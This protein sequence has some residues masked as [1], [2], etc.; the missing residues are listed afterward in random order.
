MIE[1]LERRCLLH[2]GTAEIVSGIL[3]I[4][5]T[6]HADRIVL[7]YGRGRAGQGGDGLTLRVRIDRERLTFNLA[8]FSGILINTYEGNDRVVARVQLPTDG[9]TGVTIHGGE[10]NDRLY[11]SKHADQILG[12]AGNDRIRGYGGND[13]IFGGDG[14]DLL[15]G[16][17]GDDQLDGDT[18]RDR[19]KGGGDNDLIDGDEGND[20]LWGGSGNDTLDGDEGN[21]RIWGNGG[22]DSL[23]A[24]LGSDRLYGNRGDDQLFADGAEADDGTTD[25]LNGGSGNDKAKSD[26][27]DILVGIEESLV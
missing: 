7:D 22:D 8:D 18:G 1:Q 9:F 6:D 17:K 2:S 26:A 23:V 19:I 16:D 21:D 15:V 13:S 12:D 4:N 25:F 27:E 11:G 20:R 14:N 24:G 10:G 5:G 3:E